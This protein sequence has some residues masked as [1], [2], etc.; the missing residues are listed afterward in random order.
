MADSQI[1]LMTRGQRSIGNSVEEK[2]PA[3][4]K[5]E[6]SMNEAMKS[7]NPPLMTDTTHPSFDTEPN[8]SPGT[9]T[10]V[11]PVWKV[12]DER[13]LQHHV[14]TELVLNERKSGKP[15]GDVRNPR[16]GCPISRRL[17]GFGACPTSPKISF[18]PVTEGGR[19]RCGEV[20]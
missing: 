7:E 5:R 20:R 11:T 18:S 6:V 16:R 3:T 14:R 15:H 4:G 10:F 2:T 1:T 13:R 17:S 8:A 19:K 12:A 9:G